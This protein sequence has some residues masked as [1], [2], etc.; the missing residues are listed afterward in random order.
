MKKKSF[1]QGAFILGMAGIIS[2]L[3]GALYRIPLARLLGGEGMGLYQ[4]AYP[5]YT[6]ILAMATAGV[7]VAISIL[8]ARKESAGLSG[9][10]RKIFRA[11]L[12][13]LLVVG[14]ALSVAVFAGAEFL[15]REVLHQP[16]AFLPLAAI[17]PAIFFAGM[18][19]VFRGYFQGF[20]LMMPTAVSQVIEQVFRVTFVLVLAFW[21]YPRG[22]EMAAAGATFGAV[23]GGAAGL[24][25][26]LIFYLRFSRQPVPGGALKYSGETSLELGKELIR[27]AVPVSLGAMVVPLVQMLDAVI[28]PARLISAGFTVSRATEL[29]GQLSGMAS[30]LINLPTIFTIAI[31][32][33]LVPAVAEAMATQDKPALFERIN[34]GL[35]VAML[36]AL[37]SAVGLSVL[38]YPITDLL[39]ASP[40]AGIPLAYL[41]FSVVVMAVFQ[42]TSASLQG[43]G[44]P[45]IPLR[46][47]LV[48]GA[49]K[50]VLNFYLTGLV[51]LNIKGPAIGTTV[52]FF[53]GSALNM[54]QLSHRT[55][56]KYEWGRYLKL[57]LVSVAMGLAVKSGYQVMLS[58]GLISHLSTLASILLGVGIYGILLLVAGEFNMAL[59]KR[60]ITMGRGAK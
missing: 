52:A 48:V 25:V 27:L 59:I 36:M 45:E 19:S 33:S 11:S 23:I 3:L 22:L 20:Q 8:V 39:F 6:T 21:L 34:N 9:D 53:V 5:I 4:M 55:G 30:V 13:L 56:I 31:A 28:V 54:I 26:L 14:I 57:A 50:V 51:F 10:S 37:P 47:L 42:I 35:R 44:H 15:A 38:A 41:A 24:L 2:K 58:W 32:T 46:N 7:P 18:M 1:L 40:E 12:G 17:A 60:Y 43:L 49:I 16:K 29:Y